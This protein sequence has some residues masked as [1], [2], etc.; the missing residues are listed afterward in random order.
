MEDPFRA[1]A[2][3][4][5]VA[6]SPIHDFAALER[7]WRELELRSAPCF[8]RS[9]TWVGCL[10][11]QRFPDPVLLRASAAGETVGLALLNRHK[12]R[13]L[14]GESGDPILDSPFVEHNGPLMARGYE[15]VGPALL[16]AAL[17]APGARR[18]VLSGVDP[19]LPDR[20]GALVL[21]RQERPAPW[22]DL[23]AV[24]QAG[25]D[26]LPTLSANT[27]QQLRRS[28]RSYASSGP[29]TLHHAAS[30]EQA[31]ASLERLIAL[32]NADWRERGQAGAFATTFVRRFHT[33]LI[34]RASARGE[35]DLLRIDAGDRTVGFLYNLLLG[36]VIHAYQAGLDRAGAQ[37]HEKPGL[38]CHLLAVN[39]AVTEGHSAYDLMAGAQRY[40]A[41]LAFESRK[42][43][44]VELARRSS[45]QGWVVLAAR[46]IIG[47]MR[48]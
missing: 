42:F 5:E 33:T 30:E 21:R 8:F 38:S 44:W 4:V 39:R 11:E 23:D 31:L 35:V 40:K 13:L 47:A 45:V 32:H 41:S 17:R 26:L 48:G 7:E 22:I 20:M 27:R 24:R 19:D 18:L 15:A 46:K 10:V 43:V 3:P 16:R 25:G 1:G 2:G 36:G 37:R 34:Q 14:L 29:L 12:G 9:W 6:E 28:L